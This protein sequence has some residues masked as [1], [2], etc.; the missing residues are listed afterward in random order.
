MTDS[1]GLDLYRRALQESLIT[2]PYNS[3]TQFPR[4]VE[5]RVQDPR[6]GVACVLQTI[7]VARRAEQMGAGRARLLRDGRHVA[8]VFEE[9][10]RLVV[11][12][13]YLLH[14]EPIVLP[15]GD[16]AGVEVQVPALP[17]RE[18]E[19]G[20]PV[21]AVVTAT[22]FPGSTC[23]NYTFTL[24]YTR[25]SPSR[26]ELVP[27]RHFKLRSS[28]PLGD[29]PSGDQILPLLTHP[30][31]TSLS[32]RVVEG[33]SWRMGEAIIALRGWQHLGTQAPSVHLRD[34]QGQVHA[35]D[36]SAGAA[37]VWQTLTVATGLGRKEILES[38]DDAHRVYSRIA[39]PE[40]ELAPYNLG[41]E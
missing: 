2:V 5:G 19:Q 28:K 9:G 20:E 4:F 40:A 38:F 34:N 11:L 18:D 23:E 16:G 37:E 8:A 15:L 35:D 14:T 12:D 26:Q 39:D 25:F 3:A 31:Q 36:A 13:P 22:L 7:D 32:I 29:L 24:D 30:E 33:E 1:C 6:L 21:G 10:D 27:S 17:V 41:S